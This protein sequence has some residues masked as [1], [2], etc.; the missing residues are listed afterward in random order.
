MYV[1]N[2]IYYSAS[3]TLE[4]ILQDFLKYSDA[5]VSEIEEKLKI[6][7]FRYFESIILETKS[8]TFHD[9]VPSNVNGNKSTF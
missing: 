6:S 2:L 3:G 8:R 5:Y 1:L 9:N 4:T 7:Y